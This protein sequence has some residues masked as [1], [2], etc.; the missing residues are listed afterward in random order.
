[1]VISQDG[2]ES[3]VWYSRAEPHPQPGG[4]K[5]APHLHFCMR[6]LPR[7]SS[8]TL[9]T[10]NSKS[11]L[12]MEKQ[13]RKFQMSF[14]TGTDKVKHLEEKDVDNSRATPRLEL[15]PRAEVLD[16]PQE[17]LAQRVAKVCSRWQLKRDKKLLFL[18]P[19]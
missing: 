7:A 10:R 18:S 13:R 4:A 16:C 9:M 14:G 2:N 17:P 3:M 12:K 8:A 15:A 19:P 5:A 6:A 11:L 1:M